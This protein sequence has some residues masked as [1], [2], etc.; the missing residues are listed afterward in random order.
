MQRKKT[1]SEAIETYDFD[2]LNT[3]LSRKEKIEDDKDRP[4]LKVAARKFLDAKDDTQRT[5]ITDIF[6]ALVAN[7]YANNPK[8]CAEVIKTITI[9]ENEPL[10]RK[11]TIAEFIVKNYAVDWS[12]VFTS[13]KDFSVMFVNHREVLSICFQHGKKEFVDHLFKDGLTLLQLIAKKDPFT[14]IY[15]KNILELIFNS[16]SNPT[17]RDFDDNLTAY[18]MAR[19]AKRHDL[20]E[21]IKTYMQ[22]KYRGIIA[23]ADTI[24]SQDNELKG[25]PIHLPQ[26]PKLNVKIDA[27]HLIPSSDISFDVVIGKGGFGTVYKATWNHNP[28]AVKM[29]TGNN[30]ES[31][32]HSFVEEACLF[33]NLRHPNVVPMFGLCNQPQL[34]I[35][36]EYAA[37]GSLFNELH[38][39]KD[40]NWN[41]R[42]RATQGIA[43]GLQYL[44]GKNIMHRDLKTANVLVSETGD[45]KLTDFGLAVVKQ[46][47]T[48]ST[49][50]SV[51]Q[52]VGTLPWMAP[53]LFT[54]QPTYTFAADIYSF[55]IILWEVGTREIPWKNTSA[56][57]LI[58][59]VLQGKRPSKELP[60][61]APATYKNYMKLC[62]FQEPEKRPM[63][64]E[65]VEKLQAC[66]P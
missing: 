14:D 28:V 20:A 23:P 58:G 36:M 29:L 59:A 2:A 9:F 54:E 15:T 62:L 42:I 6:N 8:A 38:S 33:L 18:Q 47:T 31:A 30:S 41:F 25:T 45:T 16:N 35:V 46:E 57:A 61:E 51:P 19:K 11:K 32:L 40:L 5:N 63:I 37:R 17:I 48:T 44:H 55:G 53:E 4:F 66:T 26:P 12:V 3:L 34:G 56:G 24:E 49:A 1:I 22:T 27:T 52:A 7:G 39:N 43:K 10:E 50:Q 21:K 13:L 65:V 60:P 64:G